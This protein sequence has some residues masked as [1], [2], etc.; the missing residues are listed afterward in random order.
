M[1]TGDQSV[2]FDTSSGSSGGGSGLAEL[3]PEA[4]AALKRVSWLGAARTIHANPMF[5]GNVQPDPWVPIAGSR[6]YQ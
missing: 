1:S 3:C 6:V 4:V 5:A 2:S